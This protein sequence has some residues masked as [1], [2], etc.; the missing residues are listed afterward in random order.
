MSAARE[1]PLTL[2]Q[3]AKLSNHYDM[4]SAL[5][6]RRINRTDFGEYG[7][8]FTPPTR[9]PDADSPTLDAE[10]PTRLPG[11]LGLIRETDGLRSN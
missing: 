9:W 7:C 2:M 4:T 1:G 8:P 11:M 10:L 6:V 5:L 3:R